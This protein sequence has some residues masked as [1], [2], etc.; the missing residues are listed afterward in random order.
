MKSC[1]VELV[2][3]GFGPGEKRSGKHNGVTVFNLMWKKPE[4][5]NHMKRFA[6]EF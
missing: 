3:F 4:P 5:T 6:T 1:W 2:G